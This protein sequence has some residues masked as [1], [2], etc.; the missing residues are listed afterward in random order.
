MQRTA[1]NRHDR[2]VDRVGDFDAAFEK[3]EPPLAVAGAS[4]EQRG[5][6]LALGVEQKTRAGLDHQI[7]A[8]IAGPVQHVR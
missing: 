6:M 7:D 8:Q 2:R 3:V 1:P 4:L 5:K